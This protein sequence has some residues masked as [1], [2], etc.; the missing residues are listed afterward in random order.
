MILS[1]LNPMLIIHEYESSKER[2]KNILKESVENEDGLD[3][4]AT[5]KLIEEQDILKNHYM[6]FIRTDLAL[7]T[8]YQTAGQIILFMLA[9]ENLESTA[10]TAGTEF[11]FRKESFE[12][13]ILSI[14]LSLKTCVSLHF[15]AV[16]LEK[17]FFPITSKIL[18]H[19]CTMLSVCKRIFVMIF[20]FV[21]SFGLMR[22]LVHWTNEKIP[23]A[24]RQT[25][26]ISSD[27]IFYIFGKPKVLWNEVDRYFLCLKGGNHSIHLLG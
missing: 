4:D 7:E 11:I 23:F 6:D 13:L 25:R 5:I 2:M 21:P 12:N 17:P 14:L 27:A 24:L 26:N 10:T 9:R 16:S 19:I 22:L 20:F 15:K 18:V 8:V 1:L 3:V